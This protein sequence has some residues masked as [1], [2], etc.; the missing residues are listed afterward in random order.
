MS[1]AKLGNKTEKKRTPNSLAEEKTSF[2]ESLT[3]N[4]IIKT[5]TSEAA[6]L[7]WN[8]RSLFAY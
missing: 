6:A 7:K 2:A 8:C 5:P 1:T 4:G 3:Q